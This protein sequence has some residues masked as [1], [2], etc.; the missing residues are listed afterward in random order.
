GYAEML[1]G[2]IW[3]ESE[4]GV[5]S[6]FYFTIPYSVGIP[7][8]TAVVVEPEGLSIPTIG[9]LRV[10]LAEDEE[11]TVTLMKRLLEPYAK[12]LFVANNGVEAIRL[13]KEHP[14]IELIMMD[15]RMPEMSGY[16][17]TRRIRLFNK[18]VVIVAQTAFAMHGDREKAME[19]GF[20]DYI[21]KP[22]SQAALKNLF[23]NFHFLYSEFTEL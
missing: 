6:S 13:M 1:G 22:V 8:E 23:E 2:K 17:A 18:K 4:E 19:L 15:I 20:N 10:L 11:T 21:T 16:E 12:E 14:G 5:G 3:V 7:G 9:K